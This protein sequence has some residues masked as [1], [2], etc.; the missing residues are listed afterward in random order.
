[1]RAAQLEGQRFGRLTVVS[2]GESKRSGLTWLCRCDCGGEARPTSSALIK[3]N[4]RSCG[5]L[6]LETVT[7]LGKR[8]TTGEFAGG[9]PTPERAAWDAMLVR[10]YRPTS[11]S[12]KNY[13]GR[14]ITV[15]DSWRASYDAFLR[16]MGRRPSPRHSL[17]RKDNDGPYSPDN[18]RWSTA[19][20]QTRNRRTTRIEM[21]EV[22]QVQWLAEQ[23]YAR[24]EIA[25]FFGC[26]VGTIDVLVRRKE[27]EMRQSKELGPAIDVEAP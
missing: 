21:H 6:Q 5:C 12:Y 23:G 14:G 15:C 10:C 17:D 19:A 1:M 3:G 8:T 11:K 26:S 9:K 22:E 4:T 24:K 20:E 25:R 27:A 13:G 7:A 16:D 2:R 18:C